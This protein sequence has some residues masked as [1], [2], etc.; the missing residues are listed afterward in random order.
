MKQKHT[1]TVLSAAIISASFVLGLFAVFPLRDLARDFASTSSTEDTTPE[2]QEP[3]DSS[4]KPIED[5]VP[6]CIKQDKIIKN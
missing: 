2:K 4:C 3:T 6:V 1:P 5:I